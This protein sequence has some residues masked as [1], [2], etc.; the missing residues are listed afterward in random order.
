VQLHLCDELQRHRNRAKGSFALLFV[1]KRVAQ[2]I[3]SLEARS[4]LKINCNSV[5]EFHFSLAVC[6]TLKQ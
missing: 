1:A 4:V 3:L 5:M 2:G 6:E